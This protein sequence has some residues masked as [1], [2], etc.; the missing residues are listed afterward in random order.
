VRGYALTLQ[1][2]VPV[3][4][5]GQRIRKTFVAGGL[6]TCTDV[7]WRLVRDPAWDGWWD[8]FNWLQ[9]FLYAPLLFFSA[10]TVWQ[11]IGAIA[12]WFYRKVNRKTEY[13]EPEELQDVQRTP[14]FWLR[15]SLRVCVFYVAACLIGD[16]PM[17]VNYL[18]TV[19]GWPLHWWWSSAVTSCLFLMVTVWWI[20]ERI[21]RM[22]MDIIPVTGRK[23]SQNSGDP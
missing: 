11:L 20:L 8:A 10:A 6:L 16:I 3:G 15:D 9:L 12:E 21:Y 14:K 17:A 7:A 4:R 13:V 23:V 2:L 1:Q 18:A 19:R 22:N 5:L